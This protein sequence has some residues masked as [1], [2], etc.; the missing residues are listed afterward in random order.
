MTCAK[1]IKRVVETMRSVASPDDVLKHYREML[2]E[3][4]KRAS[5]SSKEAEIQIP[6]IVLLAGTTE[7]EK[8]LLQTIGLPAEFSV[9]CGGQTRD[10]LKKV[11]VA[12]ASQLRL[13][14]WQ[15]VDS[16]DDVGL[17]EAMAKR[18]PKVERNGGSSGPTDSLFGS[19]MGMDDNE[20]SRLDRERPDA[21]LHYLVGLV[22]AGRGPEAVSNAASLK[23]GEVGNEFGSVLRSIDKPAVAESLFDFAGKV[24]KKDSPPV[25]E[26]MYFTLA[27]SL[28]RTNELFAALEARIADPAGDNATRRRARWLL[29]QAYLAADEVDKAIT[30]LRSVV[31]VDRSGGAS[32]ED[33]EDSESVEAATTLVQLGD[34]L[35]RR[36]LLDEGLKLLVS[37]AEMKSGRGPLSASGI[38]FGRHLISE[39][40]DDV[41]IRN[42]RTAEL[43]RM[44][45]AS[46]RAQ[47]CEQE[48]QGRRGMGGRVTLDEDLR[49]LVDLYGRLGRHQ[50]VLYLTRNAVWWSVGDVADVVDIPMAVH[51]AAALAA[52]GSTSNATAI[53]K[54]HLYVAQGDDKAYAL[55]AGIEGVALIP[56]LDSLYARDRFEERPLIWKAEILRKAGKLD[57]AEKTV[58]GALKVDPT[59]GEEPPGDRVRAY[60]VLGDI[61]SDKGKKE[62]SEFF[63]NVVKS[64]RVA[65]N[66]DRLTAVGLLKRSIKVYEEAESAFADAYCVQW[67]LAERLHSTGKFDEAEKH[68]QTA[69]E[70]MP[71]Q[72]GQVANFCFGCEGVFDKE[73]SRSVAERVLGKLV[74]THPDR[75]QIHFMI[76][77]LREAQGR[78]TEAYLSFKKD[79]ELDPGYL[80]AWEKMSNLSS[81]L[82]LPQAQRDAIALKGLEM[83]PLGRHFSGSLN[84]VQDLKALWSVLSRNQ[85]YNVESPRSLFAMT[86]SR[87]AIDEERKHGGRVSEHRRFDY[88]RMKP[89]QTICSQQ[90]ASRIIQLINNAHYARTSMNRGLFTDSVF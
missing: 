1:E 53:L 74:E 40:L 61:L 47:I 82:L 16:S 60:A 87:N 9:P 12:N 46:M 10:L 25:F 50:D 66:G 77:Q 5:S 4:A 81:L 30:L 85:R 2:E 26:S 27:L 8:L 86:A 67:R 35:G 28:G 71:E 14:Q 65:E 39:S 73:H 83:D 54:A 75:P 36:E 19:G 42:G 34:I 63:R 90:V 18:F 89:G 58:R 23:A 51:V 44:L 72:F 56:W 24:M 41:L 17:Y 57:E 29:I 21:V 32:S 70:R 88:D 33:G 84:E 79:V 59:D 31:N 49:R 52:S 76:G 37:T 69:F 55:L 80:D 78:E 7:A 22:A 38:N 48:K 20:S 3:F 45:K 68:Y 6:D 43:E 62:D 13:P 15:L 64:V 11:I